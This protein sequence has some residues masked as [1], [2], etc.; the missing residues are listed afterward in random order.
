MRAVS[1]VISRSRAMSVS[2]ALIVTGMT[3]ELSLCGHS[4]I[5]AGAAFLFYP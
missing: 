2:M 5:V 1:S 4:T 3:R